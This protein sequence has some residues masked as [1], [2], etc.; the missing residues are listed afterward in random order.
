[1]LILFLGQTGDWVCPVDLMIGTKEN[2]VADL[3]KRIVQ[4]GQWILYEKP[5]EIVHFITEWVS[6]RLPVQK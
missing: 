5:N 3:E 4:G 1:V 6:R 2:L